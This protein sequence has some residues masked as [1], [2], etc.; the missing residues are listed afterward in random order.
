M[1]ELKEQGF[2]FEEE[3]DLGT[4]FVI[5]NGHLG[6]RGTLEEDGKASLP[7]LNVVGFYD[8][9]QDNW[10]E[11]VNMPNPF[12][13][14]AEVNGKPLSLKDNCLDHSQ[15]LILDQGLF[16]RRSEFASALIQ[17]ERFCSKANE[18]LLCLKYTLRVKE[19]SIVNISLGFDKDIYDING[20]HFKKTTY[21]RK[22]RL[23]RFLGVT[24]EGDEGE[25]ALLIQPQIRT[26]YSESYQDDRML[27]SAEA[28]EGSE[29]TFFLF[30]TVC[31][32][33]FKEPLKA[34]EEVE[35]AS[36]KGYEENKEEHIKIFQK[37]FN[38][39]RVV[40]QGNKE[41]Q[42]KIDY[43]IYLLTSAAS[44]YLTS[45]P[46][47]GFSGQTYK[48]A[49]FWDSENF[50]LPF[51]LLTDPEEAKNLILYRINGLK[52]ALKKA[53]EFSY[54]GAFYAWESQED[55]KEGC[56]K[57]NVKDVKTG[58]WVRT[59]FVDKQIHISGDI[60]LAILSYYERTKDIQI[61][62]QGGIEVLY[63]VSL[64]YLSYA[65]KDKEGTYHLN[66]VIGP[67]EYHERVDDNAFTNMVA[68]KSVGGFIRMF[69]EFDHQ[70]HHELSSYP[71]YQQMKSFISQGEDFVA[72][73][74]FPYPGTDGIIEQFKGYF[75]LKD[76]TPS[77]IKASLKDPKQ[78]WGGKD[79][80]ASKTKTIK[81]ADVIAMMSLFPFDFSL[82][83][84][85]KN[86]DYYLPY[87]E[88]GS[89]LSSSMYALAAFRLEK[90][91]EGYNF[92]IKSAG[93][94]LGGESKS[95]AGKIYIGGSHM[96]AA[97][98]SY[99]SLVYGAAGLSFIDG[100]A[101]FNPHLPKEIESLS[102][103]YLEGKEK[104]KVTID[105]KKVVMIESEEQEND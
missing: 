13:I 8:R 87:T 75:D 103:S 27:I 92:F 25:E 98:G 6:Y 71:D 45:I 24:N 97:G 90:N 47:R 100:R 89:S 10:R 51:Y 70:F 20:P 81:Q 88:H 23:V 42:E 62:L 3:K 74:Y 64:F 54:Q 46:A 40:I 49:A 17:T 83:S 76:L 22:G 57:Y 102:F 50:L 41:A 65:I 72:H 14:K 94:D 19:P 52:G 1:I 66:D 11:S 31:C 93:V 5:G 16:Q 53:K 33:F 69:A 38:S 80:P 91:E 104:K 60:A 36:K 26:F 59:Y 96:A 73:L 86:Y 55:G 67:D 37:H 48:G 85:K 84:L 35:E 43:S 9:Y 101:V 12:Y 95:W 15:S 2:S 7:A 63:Q 68:K 56:S 58:K 29:L 32:S 105:D 34:E 39:G 79:G 77:Q 61:M 21:I 28:K 82:D 4:R 18:H 99:L 44:S 30:A 78:Y